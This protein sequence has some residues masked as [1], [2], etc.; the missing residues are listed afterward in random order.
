MILREIQHYIVRSDYI[1]EMLRH[2]AA[3]V[4]A[5]GKKQQFFVQYREPFG[6]L[7]VL[8]KHSLDVLEEIQKEHG[9]MGKE[10]ALLPLP[11]SVAIARYVTVP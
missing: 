8:R 6:D 3:W 10:Q 5:E 2:D 11:N 9:L 7:E 1:G 4:D